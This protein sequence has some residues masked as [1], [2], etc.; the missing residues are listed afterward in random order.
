LTLSATSASVIGGFAGFVGLGLGLISLGGLI[1]NIR[2]VGF[3][4]FVLV[5]FIGL[6]LVN[7]LIGLIGLI[8]L[9][10]VD[11]CITS[12]VDSSASSARQLIGLIGFVI[13]A[14]TISRRLKQAAALRVGT[15]QSSA[16]KIVNV[17]FY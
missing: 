10:L 5:G 2:L 16:T 4:G 13:A 6:G 9:G 1:G 15:L 14:K 17:A 3:V 8:S 7:Q 12:L 11:L